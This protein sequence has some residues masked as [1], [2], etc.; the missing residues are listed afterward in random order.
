MKTNTIYP[1]VFRVKESVKSFGVWYAVWLYGF[2]NLWTIFVATRMIKR[3]T[4]QLGGR[5]DWSAP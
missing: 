3:A 2:D 4:A 1:S 5:I